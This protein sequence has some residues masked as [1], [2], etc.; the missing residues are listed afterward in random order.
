MWI[1]RS[2]QHQAER[3][4]NLCVYFMTGALK[5]VLEKLGIDPATPGLLGI[6]LIHYTFPG[7]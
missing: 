3:V 7:Y 1:F 6:G 5:V 4:Y 2:N